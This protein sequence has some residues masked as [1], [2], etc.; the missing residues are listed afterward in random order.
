ML[1]VRTTLSIEDEALDAARA[2]AGRRGVSLGKAI[3]ELVLR[4]AKTDCRIF[5]EDGLAILDPG[6]DAPQITSEDVY[7]ALED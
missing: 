3:S 4:G 7:R 2:Y 5:I 6:P 1:D